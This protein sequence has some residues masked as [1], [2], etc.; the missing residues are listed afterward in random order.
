MR[1]NP[2]LVESNVNYQFRIYSNGNAVSFKNWG[3]IWEVSEK[4]IYLNYTSGNGTGGHSGF[5]KVGQPGNIQLAFNA[6]L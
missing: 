6:E 2:T 4:G 3:S 5:S 1:A